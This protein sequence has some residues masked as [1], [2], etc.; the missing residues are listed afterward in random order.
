[1]GQLNNEDWEHVDIEAYREAIVGNG[2]ITG[3]QVTQSDTPAMTV[4]VS[5]GLCTVDAV[6]YEETSNQNLNISNGDATHDRKD[7][8]VYDT[9]A[10][11]PAVVAGTP[12]AA[13]IPPDIPSGDILLGIVLVEQ[14]ES[15]SILDADITED[16]VYTNDRWEHTAVSANTTLNDAHYVVT[17]DATG[18]ARTITLPTAVGILGKV[19]VVKKIDSSANT[20]TVDG[21]AAETIDGA[22]TVPLTLQWSSVIIQSN[23]T[24]WVKIATDKSNNEIRDA[25]EAATDSNTFADADH[26]KLNGIEDSANNTPAAS[27][28]VAGKIELAIT[29]EINTGTST[30]LANTPDALAGSIFGTKTVVVKCILDDADLETGD[31][32]AHMTIPIELNGMN[33]VSV[34]GHVYTVSSSGTPTF[35]IHNLTDAVD[36]LSTLITID[37]TEKDSST[38]AAAAVIN[39][40]NDDVA[41][42]DEIRLDCDVVGTGTKGME[43]RMGFRLP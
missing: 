27:T 41:T 42:G 11:N 43:I 10:G 8:V 1:M 33:L 6:V 29:S 26:T 34:G 30:A 25:V 38:A 19:Y 13:P 21:N 9:T 5:L 17:V 20:V 2:V 12:A 15:T 3:L 4:K 39:A 28:T 24:N 32:I 23:G 7:I 37:A 31:G 36:M 22:A 35:Q 40:A 14:N 16:R 18:G